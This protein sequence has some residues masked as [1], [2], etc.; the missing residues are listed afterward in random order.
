MWLPNVLAVGDNISEDE[1]KGELGF[2]FPQL[3]N[4]YGKSVLH[5]NQQGA[6]MSYLQQS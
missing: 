6:I 2:V 5:E 4:R 3:L 1:K